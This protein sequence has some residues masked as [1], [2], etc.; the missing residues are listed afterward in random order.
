[1]TK[2]EKNLLQ[3]LE[4]GEF[5]GQVGDDCYTSGGSTV[6]MIIKNGIPKRLKEGPTQKFFN[7][8]ENERKTGVL[9]VL[10]KWE[11]DEKKIAFF[12]KYGWLMRDKEVREYS[13]KF[14]P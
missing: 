13:A 1:M 5:E 4:E 6:Y 2:E 11:T 8:K 7:G 14:K 3:R 12:R 10:E 9:H